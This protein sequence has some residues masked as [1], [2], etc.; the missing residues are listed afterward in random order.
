MDVP[1]IQAAEDELVAWGILERT[2]ALAPTRRFR[3]ALLRAAATLQAEE[4]AGARRPGHPMEVTVGVALDEFP[5][6]QG[7]LLRREHRLLLVGLQ[8]A[9]MPDEIRALL[10]GRA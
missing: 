3:G 8:I 4:R 6:P 5:L 10:D 9:G 7:A 2:P 1:T